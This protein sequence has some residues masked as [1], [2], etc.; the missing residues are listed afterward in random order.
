MASPRID[1]ISN[2]G[3]TLAFTLSGVNMSLANGTLE[4]QV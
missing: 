1:K 3:D 4:M 2:D